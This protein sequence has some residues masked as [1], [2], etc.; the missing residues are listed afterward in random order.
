V[1]LEFPRE[2]SLEYNQEYQIGFLTVQYAVHNTCMDFEIS[3][4][5]L[6]T[7]LSSVESRRP[8]DGVEGTPRIREDLVK[9]LCHDKIGSVDRNE[10]PEVV[11]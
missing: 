7:F 3:K 4:Q 5:V 8:L 10:V 9:V 6:G 2:G 1:Q 11:E